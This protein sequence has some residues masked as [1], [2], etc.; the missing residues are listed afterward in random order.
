MVSAYNVLVQE[1]AENPYDIE[2]LETLIQLAY[3]DDC[4]NEEEY[5]KLIGILLKS[6]NKVDLYT[7]IQQKIELIGSTDEKDDLKEEIRAFHTRNLLTDVEFVQL[8]GILEE[9]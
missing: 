3:E 6:E 9:N 1:I 2:Y 7:E 8:I 4:I 5:D